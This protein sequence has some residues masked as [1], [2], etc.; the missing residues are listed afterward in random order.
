MATGPDAQSRSRRFSWTRN[1]LVSG[2]MRRQ[3]RSD[4]QRSYHARK[5]KP[6]ANFSRPP[7]THTTQQS[8][9][10]AQSIPPSSQQPPPTATTSTIST[11]AG[12]TGTTSR[13]YITIVSGWRARFMLWHTGGQYQRRSSD[14]YISYWNNVMTR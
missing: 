5:K 8:S 6:A 7:N 1:L 2:L 10:A 3:D 9:G 11:V 14:Y 12:A 4:I 13:P